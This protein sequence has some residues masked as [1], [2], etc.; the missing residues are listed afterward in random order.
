MH[1]IQSLTHSGLLLWCGRRHHQ[2]TPGALDNNGG[3]RAFYV[4]TSDSRKQVEEDLDMEL[5]TGASAPLA[6]L[7]PSFSELSAVEKQEESP[8][9]G[10]GGGFIHVSLGAEAPGAHE[11]LRASQ[12]FE[13]TGGRVHLPLPDQGAQV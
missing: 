7:S 5:K 8:P 2:A 13:T 4:D 1:C 11:V 9:L 10:G 12:L 6:A 3:V